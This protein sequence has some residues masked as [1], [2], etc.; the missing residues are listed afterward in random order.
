MGGQLM[1]S[2]RFDGLVSESIFEL[3][4][5]AA[6]ATRYGDQTGMVA[7]L[8]AA[9]LRAESALATA[10]ADA[11]EDAAQEFQQRLPDG[12]GNGRAYNSYTVA[13]MLRESAAA[14]RA[15]AT[16]EKDS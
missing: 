6:E 12:I 14:I 3:A 9:L 7:P 4:K 2:F 10:R 1:E 5:Q 16:T 13:Q 15:A 8:L 11:L